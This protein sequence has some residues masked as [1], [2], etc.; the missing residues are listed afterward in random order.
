MGGLE[1]FQ[2][3]NKRGGRNRLGGWKINNCYI[4]CY[5]VVGQRICSRM[6]TLSVCIV[7]MCFRLYYV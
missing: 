5:Y 4:I 2:K 3:P 1:K 6:L 7:N